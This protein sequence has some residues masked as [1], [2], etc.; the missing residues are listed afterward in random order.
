MVSHQSHSVIDT[1][2]CGRDKLGLIIQLGHTKDFKIVV[3]AFLNPF[4]L[5]TNL[6]QTTL[7]TC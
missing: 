3:D 2:Y 1:T 4:P 7:E 6:Q 5:T